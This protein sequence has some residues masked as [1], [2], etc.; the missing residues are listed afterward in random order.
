LQPPS[1]LIRS[2]VPS[3]LATRGQSSHSIIFCSI[4]HTSKLIIPSSSH[5]FQ[6]RANAPHPIIC[7][8]PPT[9]HQADR[10]LLLPI[11][12]ATITRVL[13]PTRSRSFYAFAVS[14]PF[15]SQNLRIQSRS[16]ST[17]CARSRLRHRNPTVFQPRF[18]A[19]YKPCLGMMHR[20][21]TTLR[22]LVHAPQALHFIHCYIFAA[23]V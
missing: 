2:Q 5:A 12:G 1:S 21:I 3:L 6:W 11:L 17:V 22:P 13:P 23:H 4:L 7:R 14:G 18:S 8:F 10:C 15:G 20:L 19:T 9:Y 16:V